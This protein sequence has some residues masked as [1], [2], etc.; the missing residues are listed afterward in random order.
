MDNINLVET[1]AEFAKS[2]NI[3]RPIVIKI[4]DDVFRTIIK[5]KFDADEGFDIIIN[6]DKGD[7]QIWRF[8]TIVTDDSEELGKPDRISISEAKEIEP[9]FEVGEEVSEEI[10]LISFGRR[11]IMLAK[12][13]LL[14]KIKDLEKDNIYKKY[15]PLEGEIIS[16][17]VR[18][19]LFKEIILVD[20]DGVE[21]VLPKSHQIPKDKFKKG[22]L[23]K[24][25]IDHIELH[26]KLPKIIVSRTST[27][28][29]EKLLE[30][31][32]PE[33]SDGIITIK[34]I[35]RIPGERAK[36]AVVSDDDR[37][38]PIGACVGIKG[39]RIYNI[40]RELR[41]ENID[42]INYTENL[43]LYVQ[44]ALN[45]AKINN[46]QQDED[47]E[48]R[49]GIYLNLDQVSLAI[50]K[51]GQNIRL[52]SR[53]VGKEIDVYREV[54]EDDD[55]SIYKLKDKIDSHDLEKLKHENF[56]SAKKILNTP[57]ETILRT[58]G[59]DIEVIDK[60][61]LLL[62]EELIGNTDND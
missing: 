24:S 35:V 25:V 44:R 49:I 31:N 40:V 2:K 19:T 22:E 8:R 28:F 46:V 6:L 21:F 42:V 61:Y 53:L 58:T 4:L 7:L 16:L 38:D 55:I 14:Q 56:I 54:S 26:S 20:E 30:S 37:I 41:N 43:S 5:K 3:D 39:S 33:I 13:T 48:D 27:V 57:K 12:Q 32:I 51:G 29:L 17:E 34:N 18:Q 59:I 1:F 9:D 23:V 45:P 60:I 36:V 52:A 11:I 10:P 62:E 15:S 47:D 50:G